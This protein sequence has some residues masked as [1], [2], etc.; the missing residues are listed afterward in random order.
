MWA[1]ISICQHILAFISGILLFL[2]AALMIVIVNL[3]CDYYCDYQIVIMMCL[4]PLSV[5]AVIARLSNSK[6]G[7]LPEW[8]AA[9]RLQLQVVTI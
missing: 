5:I 9:C 3:I 1:Y 2:I 7:T 8:T 6:S 4:W